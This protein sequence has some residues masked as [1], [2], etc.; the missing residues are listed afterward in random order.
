MPPQKK[1]KK[2]PPTIPS[3][4]GLVAALEFNLQLLG[5]GVEDSISKINERT[6]RVVDTEDMLLRARNIF[7]LAT[8][9]LVEAQEIHTA[10]T[11]RKG[12]K[13]V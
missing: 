12:K 1:P 2:K 3:N 9:V 6:K 8:E 11:L 10:Q 13:I 4:Y 7:R 5:N